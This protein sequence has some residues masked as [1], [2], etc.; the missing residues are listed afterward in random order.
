MNLLNLVNSYLTYESLFAGDGSAEG[1]QRNVTANLKD[2]KSSTANP[3]EGQSITRKGGPIFITNWVQTYLQHQGVLDFTEEIFTPENFP[4]L[5]S[6]GRDNESIKQL[7]FN[8]SFIFPGNE[9]RCLG[10]I[11]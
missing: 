3:N 4:F 9:E 7:I 5:L 8:E 6:F 10:I 11:S 2:D 1:P